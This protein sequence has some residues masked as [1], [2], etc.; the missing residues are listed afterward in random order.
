MTEKF[1]PYRKECKNCH[2]E[3]TAM[4]KWHDFCG[5]KCRLEHWRKEHPYL[6]PEEL[7][8]IKE[9]LGMK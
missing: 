1:K 2:G 5:N 3:F 7:S 6:S 8:K 4:R 9:R